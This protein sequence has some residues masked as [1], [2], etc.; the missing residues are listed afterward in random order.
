MGLLDGKT[1]QEYYQGN[2][3]GS[4]QFVSLDDV[5]NQF[6]V[7]YVGE[8][9]IIRKCSRTDVGF[10][11]QRALAELSFDTFKSIKAQQIDVPA[12]LVMPLPHDYV[13]Y[14]K[15]SWVDSSG[16]K[17]PLYS[18]KHT[19]NPFQIKQGDDDGS[20]SFPS[21]VEA[22]V[23]ASF[24][25]V[26]GYSPD[27]WV[28][29]MAGT[30]FGANFQSSLGVIDNK[31]QWSYVNKTGNGTVGWGQTGAIYQQ[32]DVSGF[33]YIDVS[34]DGVVADIT[35]TNAGGGTGTA[36]S[37]IR[38]GIT[39]SPP[40]TTN[41]NNH[42]TWT[43]SNNVT[44]PQTNLLDVSRFN[45]VDS[46]A[47]PAYLEWS[48][49]ENSTKTFEAVDVRNINT[50]WAVALSF[51]DTSTP[52]DYGFALKPAGLTA[53]T[54][55]TITGAG[56]INSLDNLSITNTYAS[57]TLQPKVGNEINSSTWNNYKSTTPSEINNDN[58]EDDVYWPYK[59][60]RYGLDPSHAQING[61]FYID[62][63][64]GRIHFSSNMSTKT[65]ILDY[66]SDSLGTNEEMK[67]HKFAEEAM[68]R[69]ILHAVASSYM[70][71][72]QIVPRLKKEKIAAIRQA[73]LRL[74][75]FKL[76]ELTQIL[77]GKSKQIKH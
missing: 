22:L 51:V 3:L 52:L 59:G 56:N 55:G 71:T 74:S 23:N 60:E 20:Y 73:K 8:E 72:Q 44:I 49:T 33:N 25:N 30:T 11:A 19:S 48:G 39:T 70:Y 14:T 21:G 34:A 2:D 68:Y 35:Y 77:R 54:V 46:N 31:L 64:L 36:T 15:L 42:P 76:E 17:H 6:M 27:S 16:I 47:N 13:N 69:W 10:H 9:K 65:V 61:S 58:Y 50:I 12:T 63:R 40:H 67:I 45:L 29:M 28:V 43:N 37:T 66:I 38:F 41:L 4:Y 5:I 18:T 26:T 53:S 32:I 7:V 1:H 24:D 57:T 62:D 75:N